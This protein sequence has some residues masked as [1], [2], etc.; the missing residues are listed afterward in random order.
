MPFWRLGVESTAQGLSHRTSVLLAAMH[1][2]EACSPARADPAP[3]LAPEARLRPQP[4][5]AIE[6]GG[7]NGETV[8]VMRRQ[9]G[10][11]PTRLVTEE[12]KKVYHGNALCRRGWGTGTGG[13]WRCKYV[14]S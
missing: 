3:T 14:F 11:K 1:T 5:P 2:G 6:E 7:T 8:G 10:S 4:H 12:I 9:F 13:R